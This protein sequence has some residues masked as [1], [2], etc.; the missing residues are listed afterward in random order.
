MLRAALVFT[1]SAFYGTLPALSLPA[2]LVVLLYG[3]LDRD[4]AWAVKWALTALGPFA[5]ALYWIFFKIIRMSITGRKAS[6]AWSTLFV[7]LGTVALITLM[8]KF[9]VYSLTDR[10]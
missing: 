4:T 9:G 7:F 5:A 2:L 1:R 6:G 8:L 3:W 10:T